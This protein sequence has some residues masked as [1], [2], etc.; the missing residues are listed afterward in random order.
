MRRIALL[1]ALAGCPHD[2][3]PCQ[4]DHDCNGLVCTRDF[5]CLP[6]SQVRSVKV[7]WTIHGQPADATSCAPTPGFT[8]RFIDSYTN[9]A[10]GYEPVPCMEGQFTID[11]IPTAYD[12][13]EI[14]NT[15]GMIDGNNSAALALP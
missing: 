14:E 13:V 6:S 3:G 1:V 9:T 11:K 10:F 12:Y 8:L 7:T 4:T 5:E 2:G 15:E